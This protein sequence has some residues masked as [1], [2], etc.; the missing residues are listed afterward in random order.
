MKLNEHFADYET[1]GLAL[2]NILH[3]FKIKVQ[4]RAEENFHNY[5]DKVINPRSKIHSKYP[6]CHKFKK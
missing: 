6:I 4:N 2:E 3:S 5:S 1:R